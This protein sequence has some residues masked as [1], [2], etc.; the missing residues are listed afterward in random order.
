MG[1]NFLHS[2]VKLNPSITHFEFL[3]SHHSPHFSVSGTMV[4]LLL[5]PNVHFFGGVIVLPL[6]LPATNAERLA[7]LTDKWLLL[8]IAMWI[9]VMY[10]CRPDAKAAP[11]SRSDT[12]RARWYIGNAFFIHFL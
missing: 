3:R 12:L 2:L 8:T 5:D 1:I 10:W 9:G 7:Y 11:L 6:F 4:N